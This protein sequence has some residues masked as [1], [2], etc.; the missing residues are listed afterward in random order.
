LHR[1]CQGAFWVGKNVFRSNAN[2]DHTVQF[3]LRRQNAVAEL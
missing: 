1:H 3:S 2:R